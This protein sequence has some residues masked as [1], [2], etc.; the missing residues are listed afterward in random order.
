M[1]TCMIIDDSRV[2][3]IAIR[4]AV[5]Q[6]GFQVAE[7][8]DGKVGL[9]KC[10]QSMPDVVIV[11]WNMPVM[12]GIEFVRELRKSANGTTPKVVMCTT[13]ND[14]ERIVEALTAGADEYIMKPFDAP[15]LADKLAQIG[16]VMT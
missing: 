4:R 14:H 9:D 6:L 3:R 16:V 2:I 1:K 12:N 10:L 15:I 13:E 11:D 7:A 5:E 8:E